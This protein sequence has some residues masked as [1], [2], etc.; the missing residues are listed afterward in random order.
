MVFSDNCYKVAII[1]SERRTVREFGSLQHNP[2]YFSFILTNTI[3]FDEDFSIPSNVRET[4]EG[5]PQNLTHNI[6]FLT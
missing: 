3:T 5:Q 6:D 2:R 1:D 4:Q